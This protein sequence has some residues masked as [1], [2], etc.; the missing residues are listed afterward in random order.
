[1]VTLYMT[2]CDFIQCSTCIHG[3]YF[4]SYYSSRAHTQGAQLH[5]THA[6]Q[7]EKM[8]VSG[9]K[10]SQPGDLML[11][12][13]PLYNYA[14][15]FLW[16]LS[17][18]EWALRRSYSRWFFV[19]AFAQRAWGLVCCPWRGH[20]MAP[21]I[22]SGRKTDS[23]SESNLGATICGAVNVFCIVWI[24]LISHLQRTLQQKA[25]L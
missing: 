25:V 13:C 9:F 20:W 5:P 6:N 24:P 3:P 22:L 15:F 11:D 19:W 7:E 10:T 23:W 1:M 18:Y 17:V 2:F 4:E 14:P 12:H 21:F 16:A 8:A